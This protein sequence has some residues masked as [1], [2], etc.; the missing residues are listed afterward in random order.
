MELTNVGII[1]CGNIAKIH[2]KAL[3]AIDGVSIAAF[4][5]IDLVKARS[6]AVTY[7]NGKSKLYASFDEMIKWEKRLDALHICTPHY[8]HVPMTIDALNHGINV[9][10][11]KPP[12]IKRREFEELLTRAA[13]CDRRVAVCFQN[14]YNGSFIK[15]QEILR[16]GRLGRPIGAKGIVTWNRGRE[17]YDVA[18]WKGTLSE[19]GGGVLINQSIHTLD[20]MVLM[21]GEPVQVEATFSNHRLKGRIEVEDTL[22]AFIR[23]AHADALFY[24][25][26]AYADD[27]PILLEV[28][29][30]KGKLRIEGNTL[31]VWNEAGSRAKYEFQTAALNGKAY[32][33]DS[34]PACI[35]DFYNGL[36]ENRSTLVELASVK[37]TFSLVMDIYESA[38]ENR[39][40][41][42]KEK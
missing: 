17:Y 10:M 18:A 41:N 20:L 13:G 3:Q 38:K 5:D 8:L 33:G 37:D 11:E 9:F 35:A 16:S 25:S 15:A 32:W 28:V 30:E 34:H 27:S 39:V 36:R 12:A 4:V 21:I 19:E 31:T 29:C 23:F 40:V 24:A 1:G 42:R 26:N 14:R 6:L 7:G 22:E 2:A